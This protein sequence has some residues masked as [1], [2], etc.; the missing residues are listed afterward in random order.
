MVRDGWAKNSEVRSW[1]GFGVSEDW[2]I[3]WEWAGQ[4]LNSRREEFEG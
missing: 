3:L 1:S 2:E 4:N